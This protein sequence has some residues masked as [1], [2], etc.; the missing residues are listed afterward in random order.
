MA[1]KIEMQLKLDI[2]DEAENGDLS[3]RGVFY[4]YYERSA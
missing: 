4:L 2:V 1:H 3:F